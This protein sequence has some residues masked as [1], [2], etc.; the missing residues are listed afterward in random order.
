MVRSLIVEIDHETWPA[1]PGRAHAV[2]RLLYD[3]WS[4]GWRVEARS[5]IL[6][7]PIHISVLPPRRERSTERQ[8]QPDA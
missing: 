5:G 7:T 3:T 2:H 8:E 4:S 6:L 1:A